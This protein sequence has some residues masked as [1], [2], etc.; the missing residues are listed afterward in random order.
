MYVNWSIVIQ[1]ITK[2]EPIVKFLETMNLNFLQEPFPMTPHSA[3][4]RPEME[5]A[6]DKST[7]NYQV[8]SETRLSCHEA[9]MLTTLARVEH[10][11]NG[12]F[13]YLFLLEGRVCL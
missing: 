11:L 13:N 2:Y 12:K 7:I 1:N 8:D 3:C 5:N 4:A 6:L 9:I 10:F